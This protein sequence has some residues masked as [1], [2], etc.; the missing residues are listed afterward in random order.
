MGAGRSEKFVQQS[1]SAQVEEAYLPQAWRDTATYMPRYEQIPIVGLER[2]YNV[3]ATLPSTR[4][5]M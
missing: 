1:V 4:K 2:R 3:Y 5:V